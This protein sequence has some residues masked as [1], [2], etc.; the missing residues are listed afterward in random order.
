MTKQPTSV[1]WLYLLVFGLTCNG[2]KGDDGNIQTPWSYTLTKPARD[3]MMPAF[4][5][6]NWPQGL[7]GFGVPDTPNARVFTL[8]ESDDIWLRKRVRIAKEFAK[9]AL[10]VH[11]DEDAEIYLDGK[12]IATLKGYVTNYRV[13][14]ID[15]AVLASIAAGEHTLAVHCHQTGGG[16]FIDVHI[17]DGDN[18]PQLP[19]P[20]PATEPVKSPL[21]TTWGSQ[22]TADNAWREYPRPQMT[23]Q[24]WINLNGHW[25][26]AISPSADSRPTTWQGKI[27]VPYCLESKLSGVQR[28]LS[29]EETLWYHRT[30]QLKNK[31]TGRTLLHFEAVDYEATV[32]VNDRQMGTHTGGNVPFS[33]DVTEVIREG[34]NS[35][36]VRVI[37]RTEGAQLRGK[38]VL[39]P[40]GIW[41][42]RV[43]GIWQTVWMEQVPARAVESLN[44][45]GDMH[46]NVTVAAK[47]AGTAVSGERVQVEVLDGDQVVAKGEAG[48]LIKVD[49]PKL[50][51]PDSPHLY[52]LRVQVNNGGGQTV[53][54]VVSYVGLRSVGKVRDAEGHWRFTL[55]G[56]PIFHWGPLDQGW[57]PDGL[58]TPPSLDAI[59]FEID[60]LKNAGFNMIRKH[61]KVEPRLYYHYCDRVGM[62]VWQDQVSGGR[63][64]KW[65]RFEPNPED[66]AWA[67]SDHQQFMNEFEQMVSTL[68]HFPC[69]VVWT[70]FNEAWGQH[71]TVEVGRW[72]LQRDRSR[73]I[74]IASG[75]NFWPVGDIVDWHEYPHPKFPFDPPRFKDYIL[76]VGE[77]G[78]HGWPVEGHLWEQ[79]RRNWGYGGLPK[80]I[81][82]YRER[83]KESVRL[84]VELKGQGIAAGVYTQTTD[85]EGEING[86]LTYDRKVKKIDEKTLQQWTRPLMP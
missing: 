43:S 6:A 19:S 11:H 65:T 74:N 44:V 7:G 45:V 29:P 27:L 55:N 57:W 80:T 61:I 77:F 68:E 72:A 67:D 81:E 3:W 52:S 10:F 47:L 14:A 22:V 71:R 75:G 18:I 84:L 53:D 85:V 42:T 20:P 54:E 30:V 76:A 36:V 56:K 25:D 86:L 23:R 2:L 26:Y 12:P 17:I 33:L 49:N 51:S 9:P 21:I 66:A 37:D 24:Q 41:Y 4:D 63:D 15:R 78:G 32:W 35:L 60:Y 62:L 16:Q 83:I 64:P 70:P 5:A 79:S 59:R 58:L 73:L 40:N 31:P 1:L 8:W 48:A 82:E 46:G 34:E 13:V 38:Q 28:L 39:K 69:I 50:W